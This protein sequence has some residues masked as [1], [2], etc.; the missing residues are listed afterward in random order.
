MSFLFVSQKCLNATTAT[1]GT[2]MLCLGAANASGIPANPV[3]DL[4]EKTEFSFYFLSYTNLSGK[5]KRILA[6]ALDI[7]A[8]SFLL[9]PVK[10]PW[11]NDIVGSSL[12]LFLMSNGLYARYKIKEKFSPVPAALL[13]SMAAFTLINSLR[14]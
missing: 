13:S 5:G 2:L 6:G 14:K 3:M 12:V 8:A 1:L 11:K 7:L 10:C 4:W 9:A